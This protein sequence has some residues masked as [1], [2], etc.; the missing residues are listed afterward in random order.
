[1]DHYRVSL[2]EAGLVRAMV[3]RGAAKIL[4][5]VGDL[6]RF[7]ASLGQALLVCVAIHTCVAMVGSQVISQPAFIG[8]VANN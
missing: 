6:Y 2:L 8:I 5:E 7:S 4:H 3:T 1:M